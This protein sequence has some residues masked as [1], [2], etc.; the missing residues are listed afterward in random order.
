MI[1]F[2]LGLMVLLAAIF[3]VMGVA[4]SAHWGQKRELGLVQYIAYPIFF[5]YAL[6]TL[7]SGRD[8]SGPDDMMSLAVAKSSLLVWAGRFTSI[9]LIFACGERIVRRLLNTNPVKPLP[10]TLL[11][12]FWVFFITN[13]LSPA[14]FGQYFYMSHEFLYPLL[15]CQAALLAQTKAEVDA[16]TKVL[17]NALYAFLIASAMCLVWKHSLVVTTNYHGLI[18]GLKLRYAG[19]TSH[20]NSLGS[21]CVLFMLCLWY[22]PLKNRWLIR[23]GWVIG[24]V[25]LV[26]TQSKTSWIAFGLSVMVLA[27]YSRRDEINARIQDFRRPHLPVLLVLMFMFCGTAMCVIFMFGGAGDKIA[28]FFT[29]RDGSELMTFMGRDQIWQVAIEEWRKYPVFGYGLNIFDEAFRNS[30][31]MPFAAHAHS[32]FFQ[33]LSSAGSVGAAGFVFYACAIAYFVAKTVRASQGL[34]LALFI[35]LVCKSISEVPLSM[36]GLGQDLPIHMLQLAVLVRY[37]V[38]AGQAL[39]DHA[40]QRSRTAE[41]EWS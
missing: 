32:Q 20:A 11:F 37:Y 40:V 7:L 34:S 19:L 10:G 14:F 4:F 28:R 30:V 25:S 15:A 3:L 17:R 23:F 29:S 16:M 35:L 5:T 27:W 1:E 6:S 26:L 18:P 12:A 41:G 38:P 2:V 21:L 31:G 22:Q 33:S 8:L 9:F 39:R 24:I 36:A 13:T